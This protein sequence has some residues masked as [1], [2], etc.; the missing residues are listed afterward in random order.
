MPPPVV[1][2]L[3]DD[4]VPTLA[5]LNDAAVPAVNALGTAG[6]R[7]HLP[8]CRLALVVDAGRGPEALLL[9]L[10][11]GAD[12]ASENYSWFSRERPGSLYVDRVVVAQRLRRLGVGRSLYAQ[13]AAHAA[14]HGFE[15]VTCE[16]NLEPPNPD[17]LAFHR[18]LGFRTVGRQETKGGTVRVALMAVPTEHLARLGRPDRRRQG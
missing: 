5:R 4:D 17:S 13:V 16:V 7:D 1:R 8:R 12:Y 9:A 3:W 14:E 6:L 2:P 10:G 11:P 18:S 15:E